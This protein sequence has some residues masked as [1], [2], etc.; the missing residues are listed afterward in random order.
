V[1]DIANKAMP[2]QKSVKTPL[3]GLMSLSK[4]ANTP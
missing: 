3:K 1:I 2:L 4:D